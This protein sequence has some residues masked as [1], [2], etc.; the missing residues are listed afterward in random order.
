MQHPL[1]AGVVEV[2]APEFHHR[3]RTRGG[4]DEDREDGPVAQAHG[5]RRFDR[6]EQL[7]RLR[8]RDLG[9][10]PF[11]HLIAFAAHGER[12]VEN[13]GVPD[14]QAVEEVA[15]SGQVLFAARDARCV[16]Q[17]IEVAADI[18]RGNALE[19]DSLPFRPAQELSHRGQ[20]G[21]A[22]MRVAD[23]AKEKF[24]GGEDGRRAGALDD[25]GQELRLRIGVAW[26][27]ESG[28][29]RSMGYGSG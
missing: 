25:G 26:K 6:L 11:H 1:F 16:P 21:G 22:G 2:A 20:V 19:G 27:A 4:I 28:G 10:F 7:P 18:S 15:Q 13:D 29:R 24:A 9:R 23:G 17:L 5:G 12:R 3:S 14:D 8:D